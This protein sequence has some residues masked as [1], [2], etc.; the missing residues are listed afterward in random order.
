M[1]VKL[2]IKVSAVMF[3]LQRVMLDTG[4][5]TVQK[6]ATVETATAAVTL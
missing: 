2:L 6:P 3:V 1:D 4:E 5:L